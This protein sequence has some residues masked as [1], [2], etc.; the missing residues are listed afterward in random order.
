LKYALEGS[1]CVSDR[2]SPYFIDYGRTT[3]NRLVPLKALSEGKV[4]SFREAI[5]IDTAHDAK[6]TDLIEQAVKLSEGPNAQE[7]I[8]SIAKLV[9]SKLG[10][11]VTAYPWNG[12]KFQINILKKEHNSDVLSLGDIPLGTFYH[13]ALLFKLLMDESGYLCDLNIGKYPKSWNRVHI[14]T[15]SGV[16]LFRN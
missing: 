6:L 11:T 3:L 15:G 5:L 10:G 12:F 7:N 13:R 1:I 14:P 8:R 4:T 16:Y 9:S 2:I